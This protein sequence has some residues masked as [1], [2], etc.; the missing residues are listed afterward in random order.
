LNR[1][2]ITTLKIDRS[3]V[4]QMNQ[5]PKTLM[6]VEAIVDLSRR[7]GM[8]VVAEGVETQTQLSRLQ[9]LNC[10]MAQ[11]FLFAKPLDVSS[12]TTLL[13]SRSTG[14]D[15]EPIAL[16]AFFNAMTRG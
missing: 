2:P 5:D 7:M 15:D 1:F 10:S 4:N 14:I 8:S 3:F 13:E 6:V 12:A 11:G 9:S 16:T